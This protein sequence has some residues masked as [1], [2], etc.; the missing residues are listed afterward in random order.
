MAWGGVT[1]SEG[2]D[3]PLIRG[4]TTDFF[5]GREALRHVDVAIGAWQAVLRDQPAVF[6]PIASAPT[7]WRLLADVDE[8]ALASL[9]SARAQARQVAWL[10]AAE[11]GEGIPAAPGPRD[12]RCPD[13]SW[14]PTPRSSPATQ[15]NSRPHPPIK[16]ASGS[17]RC[18]ASSPT[19]AR[20]CP[21]G[22]GP[23]MPVPTPRAT[24]SR[25]STRRSGRSP[26]S[27]GTAPTSSSAPTAPDPRKSSSP[28]SATCANEESVPASP[29]DEN[30]AQ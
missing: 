23:G 11:H 14:T 26:T 25:C 9:A 16:A 10:Q 30:A 2:T 5:A 28:T 8:T 1:S 7:A 20:H 27:T 13:W 21:A 15:R 17:I 12:A 19:P 6:G 22:Y 29:M 4:M 18:C 24:T 3:R